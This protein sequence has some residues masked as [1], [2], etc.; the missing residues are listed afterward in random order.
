MSTTS[1]IKEESKIHLGAVDKQ[2]FSMYI[3]PLKEQDFNSQNLWSLSVLRQAVPL[4]NTTVSFH[5]NVVQDDFDFLNELLPFYHSISF[6]ND[7]Y[8]FGIGVKIFE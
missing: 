5:M 1:A 7:D 4:P 2:N 3:S 6:L 8:G